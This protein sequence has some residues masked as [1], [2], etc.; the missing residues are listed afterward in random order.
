MSGAYELLAHLDLQADARHAAVPGRVD[1]AAGATPQSK[2]LAARARQRAAASAAALPD[3]HR[4]RIHLHTR[5]TKIPCERQSPATAVPR[6]HKLVLF[7]LAI[8]VTH[9]AADAHSTGSGNAEQ[10]YWIGEWEFNVECAVA[11][12]VAW[13]AV[14]LRA[15]LALRPILTV[16]C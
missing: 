12:S 1:R 14:T 13:N 10:L 8:V 9:H 11:A 16:R 5:R 15:S 3:E 6:N 7:C 2:L 4:R